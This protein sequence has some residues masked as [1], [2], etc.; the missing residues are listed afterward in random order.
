MDE[1]VMKRALQYFHAIGRVVM[2]DDNTV[3][4]DPTIVPKIAAEF[5]SP[6]E[7][8]DKLLFSKGKVEILTEGNIKC[9]LNI[10]D[11]NDP[12]FIFHFIFLS[13]VV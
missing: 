3:C 2:L 1:R 9:L 5:I 13:C 12:R 10:K 11:E 7:V 6:P 8:R 4:T